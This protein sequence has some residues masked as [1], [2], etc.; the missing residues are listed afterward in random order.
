MPLLNWREESLL[1]HTKQY[2]PNIPGDTQWRLIHGTRGCRMHLQGFCF[3]G[4]HQR[5]EYFHCFELNMLIVMVFACG[6]HCPV[7]RG[8]GPSICIGAFGREFQVLPLHWTP[9]LVKMTKGF[10]TM[11]ALRMSSLGHFLSPFY[12]PQFTVCTGK[13]EGGVSLPCGASLLPGIAW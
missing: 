7:V 13:H 3:N 6:E 9:S 1:S 8:L 11:S 2:L 4:C 5:K 12:C 10:D